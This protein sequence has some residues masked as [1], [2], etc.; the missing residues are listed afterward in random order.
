M[1]IAI[2][3][4]AGAGKSTAAKMLAK[5]LNYLYLDTG[6]MYRALT[7]AVLNARTDLNDPEKIAE[8]AL[9]STVD[10]DSSGRVLLDGVD[11]E[12]E[13]RTPRVAAHTSQVAPVA[14]VRR[15]LTARMR[16][17]AGGRNVIMDGRDIGSVVLPDADYKFFISATPEERARRRQSEFIQKGLDTE[18]SFE[19]ILE[20]IKTRDRNDSE[21]EESPLVCTDDAV[22]IMTDD[23]TPGDVV[24]RMMAMIEKG[25]SSVL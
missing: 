16:E 11:V 3:G 6:A 2:D 20:D 23:M 1:Q 21:R 17:I 19:K 25:G 22:R 15:Y 24:N 8:T 14:A 4:P 7:L 5:E 12:K 13:I 10:F 18:N 9:G